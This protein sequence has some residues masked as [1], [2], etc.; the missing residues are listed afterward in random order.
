M[1]FVP[2]ST[3]TVTFT[4]VVAGQKTLITQVN[5][6]FQTFTDRLNSLT[7]DMASAAA[8]INSSVDG[9]SNVSTN[10][11]DFATLL[12][13]T[14][15]GTWPSES[16]TFTAETLTGLKVN[17]DMHFY[18][19]VGIATTTTQPLIRMGRPRKLLKAK[20]AY[21]R[22]NTLAVSSLC[23]ISVRKGVGATATEIGQINIKPGDANKTWISCAADFA[24]D[25][26]FAIDD[27]LELVP[28]VVPG[29]GNPAQD[30]SIILTFSEVVR[31]A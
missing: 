22:N 7:A 23:T 1:S 19:G 24:A 6:P 2:T 28:T 18:Y 17:K 29:S 16:Y 27:Y 25:V 5:T 14:V 11:H 13:G 12:G 3:G 15:T 21:F 26:D 20:V 8:A 9:S 30:I 4:P 10:L 31:V